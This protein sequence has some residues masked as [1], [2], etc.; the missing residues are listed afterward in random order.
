ME[1]QKQLCISLRHGAM[2][3]QLVLNWPTW[4]NKGEINKNNRMYI[5]LCTKFERNTFFFVRMEYFWDILF[6]LLKH[7][8][9]SFDGHD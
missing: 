3:Y 2:H 6:Q 5:N 1:E 8:T 4:L 9:N 7:A